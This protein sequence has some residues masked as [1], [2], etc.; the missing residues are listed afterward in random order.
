MSTKYHWDNSSKPSQS[1]KWSDN[2]SLG[3]KIEI[4]FTRFVQGA[5]LWVID[6]ISDRFVDIFDQSMK[7]LQPGMERVMAPVINDVLNNPGISESVKASIRAVQSE[8]GESGFVTKLAVWIYTIRASIFGGLS[9]VQR[10]AEY[11][12]DRTMRT[13]LPDPSTLGFM[14]HIGVMSEEGFQN[15]MAQLG[16]HDKLIPLYLELAK[17]L[18]NTGEIIAGLWRGT[19]TEGDF[20]ALLKRQ[21]YDDKSIG[22]YKELSNQLPPLQDLIHMLVRDAFNDSA[23]GKYGYDEDFP[24]EINEFFE[25]QG[26]KPEWAKRYWRSHWNLPSPNQAYEML[27]RG[28]IDQSD[29]ETL[30][31]ISDYPKFWREKLKDISFNVMTR[32]DVRR[33]LQAGLIDE[34]KTLSIYKQMGYTPEDA[35]LLTKFAVQG[36]TQEERD[37]TKTDILN[38]YEETL[39]DRG[40][41]AGDLVKMGYDSSEAESILKLSDVAI[42]KAERSDLINFTKE[43]FLGKKI[44]ENSARSELAQIGLKAQ[45]VDRYILNWNRATEVESAIPS[46]ADVKK[47][48]LADYIDEIKLRDYL[49]QHRHTE[50]NITL[51]VRQLNDQKEESLN[52]QQA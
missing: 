51:Y 12:A 52:E 17:R 8:K 18:P 31:R 30:L 11:N 37:L 32:V 6:F 7:I 2:H 15:S 39:I 24:Q 1:N 48:Y 43:K 10:L 50:E 29:L 44:D 4:M 33:L 14:R 34:G 20:A 25:K 5:F 35:E 21:G 13:F 47:W 28:I 49:A 38:L 46:I 22:L 45:S 36:I 40:T 41:A 42:A 27:H 16:L 3:D 26:Y 23:A 19:I 9:P